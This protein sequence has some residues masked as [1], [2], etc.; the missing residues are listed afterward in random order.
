MQEGQ[1]PS[2]PSPR[3]RRRHQTVRIV[4]AAYLPRRKAK[5]EDVPREQPTEPIALPLVATAGVDDLPPTPVTGF[6]AP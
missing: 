2:N 3:L 5:C 6:A 4:S 1:P